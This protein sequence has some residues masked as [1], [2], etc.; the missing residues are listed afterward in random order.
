MAGLFTR[1]AA[2]GSLALLF[3]YVMSGTASVCAFYAL[4]AIVILTMWRTSSWLDVDGL[5]AS[6]RQ[7]HK[8][9]RGLHTPIRQLLSR[10]AAGT[11]TVEK[12]A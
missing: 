10:V 9:E 1:V 5:V 12:A 3:T 11:P 2:L 4:C 8:N 6:Y 7:H